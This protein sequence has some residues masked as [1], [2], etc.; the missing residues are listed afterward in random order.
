M[1][2]KKKHGR[3]LFGAQTSPS[4][5]SRAAADA[6]KAKAET[7]VRRRVKAL[8]AQLH[9][10]FDGERLLPHLKYKLSDLNRI[11]SILGME[12]MTAEAVKY[13]FKELIPTEEGFD[14]Y[15]ESHVYKEENRI[16][17]NMGH[18]YKK[19][20]KITK[21]AKSDRQMKHAK[22]LYKSQNWP[23][24]NSASKKYW[25][26]IGSV[27]YKAYE[28]LFAQAGENRQGVWYPDEFLWNASTAPGPA[29]Q[30]KALYQMYA[31]RLLTRASM[32]AEIRT[33][34]LNLDDISWLNE[35][36]DQS[37]DKFYAIDRIE[38]VVTISN[39]M[40]FSPVNL[41]IYLCKAKKA[42]LYSP[43]ACWFRPDGSQ[44]DN[45]MRNDY[46][47]GSQVQDKNLP[48]EDYSSLGN[49]TFYPEAAVHLG[50]TPFYSP[51]F[52]EHWAVEQVIKQQILPTDKFELTLN[53]RLRHALS[54]RDME[55]MIE[56][57][58][59][60]AGAYQPGD[61]ALLI[62]FRGEP[63]FMRFV[64]I[65]QADQVTLRETDCTPSS[66]TVESRSSMGVISPNL[67]NSD[68]TPTGPNIQSNY[69]AGEGRVLDTELQTAEFASDWLPEVIS[70]VSVE[71]GGSR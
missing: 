7:F 33:F 62:T 8:G 32:Y 34:L 1:A 69:I 48:G 45:I 38:D 4:S 42:S 47:Y 10:K 5:V 22:A 39:R 20:L 44:Q 24:F 37:A 12:G 31:G 3:N 55:A 41:K 6:A 60:P 35:D 13:A 11:E 64:G 52:R 63:G 18:I 27:Q 40:K 53:R 30:E 49:I 54:I 71:E 56:T 65:P 17:Q 43:Q 14:G 21:G 16:G 66:I 28:A 29:W 59:E 23:C 25:A 15:E 58:N 67:F 51:Q 46:V 9:E 50:A 26:R 70:N 61:Y 68:N 36:D 57:N 2:K 19:Y